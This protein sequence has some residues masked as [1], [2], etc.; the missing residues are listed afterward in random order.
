MNG[1]TS[2]LAVIGGIVTVASILVAILLY[3]KGVYSKQKME[4]LRLDRDDAQRRAEAWA[5]ECAQKDKALDECARNARHLRTEND[6]FRKVP[7]LAMQEIQALI[8]EQT[9]AILEAIGKAQGHPD[10]RS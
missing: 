8:T 5:A 2:G 6:L 1:I 3:T 9:D 10:A 7:Q 4:E